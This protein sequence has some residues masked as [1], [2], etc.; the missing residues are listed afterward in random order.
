MS[1][2]AVQREFRRFVTS[3]QA[4]VLCIKGSWGIGKT[5]AWKEFLERLDK[6][7]VSFK[8]YS[9]VSLFGLGTMDQVRSAIV[10]SAQ[11][12]DQIGK[13]VN[14]DS[15]L[16]DPMD[17]A[18]RGWRRVL[19]FADYVPGQRL[20]DLAA[21]LR[22]ASFLA[23]Y[24]YLICID[25]L[26]R[27]SSK[28]EIKD[29]LGLISYLSEQRQCNV[30]L[31][32]NEDAFTAAERNEF[33]TFFEKT[34]DSHVLFA[35]TAEECI[36][37]AFKGASPMYG[38]LRAHCLALN[39]S[40]IR[41]LKKIERLG[42]MLETY[43]EHPNVLDRALKTAALLGWA[44]YGEKKP[45]LAYLKVRGR[46]TEKSE[47]M[48]ALERTWG[49][50]LTEYGFHYMTELDE[51]LFGGAEN[52]FF[53]DR[54]LR[55]QIAKLGGDLTAEEADERY[56]RA[57]RR[58]HDSFDDDGDL[59][60]DELYSSFKANVMRITPN[61]ANSTIAMLKVLGRTE[62]ATELIQFYLDQR[63][64]AILDRSEHFTENDIT[65]PEFLRA[66]EERIATAKDDR[67]PL[68]VLQAIAENKSWSREDVT[69]LAKLSAD[70]FYKIFKHT[71]GEHF[72]AMVRRALEFGSNDSGNKIVRAATDA[73]K[74]IGRENA[75]NKR[76]VEKFGVN[77]Q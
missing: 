11:T 62:Q 4:E 39:I 51:V 41:V 76:R 58:Y 15:L 7:T 56:H 74:R 50:I 71:R 22:A 14:L 35:P 49:N 63:G 55:E 48:T 29:V 5:Y 54:K 57:W 47:E 30:C 18:D 31:I 28:L 12:P 45:P 17:A 69:L 16:S 43:I 72:S 52:G 21:A 68:T 38:P 53:D 44:R 20:R 27:R 33:N 24:R 65:E 61:N 34:I 70:D 59:L 6:T 10:E 9:Y 25:D 1:T 40:N 19:K 75:L 32:L 37:T 13:P 77:V 23:V 26:E 64:V 42:R 3:E 8:R 60:A 2:E 66:F 46:A 67:N 36:E 73:L